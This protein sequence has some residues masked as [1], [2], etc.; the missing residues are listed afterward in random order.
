M[1][2]TSFPDSGHQY[3]RYVG[4]NTAVWLKQKYDPNQG[5]L[6]FGDTFLFDVEH[7]PAPPPP[8][9]RFNFG[10]KNDPV[11]VKIPDDARVMY[12]RGPMWNNQHILPFA[13]HKRI[14]NKHLK[15]LGKH[16]FP[17]WD[18]I[19]GKT[20]LESLHRVSVSVIETRED[21]EE[22]CNLHL[23]GRYHIRDA[24]HLTFELSFDAMMAKM[25]FSI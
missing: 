13:E 19:P 4:P 20:G 9:T 23:R 12:P 5:W 2:P 16:N 25:R 3:V 11:Y 18:R 17:G 7:Q 15:S 10:K 6:D 22:W 8:Y 21:I 1:F 14:N 24:R